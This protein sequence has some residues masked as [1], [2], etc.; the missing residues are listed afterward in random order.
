MPRRCKRGRK[1]LLF[2]SLAC[3]IVCG[4][5]YRVKGMLDALAVKPVLR[6]AGLMSGTSADGIDAAIVDVSR[7]GVRQIAFDTFPYPAGIRRQIFSLFDPATARVD[8]LCH[9]NFVIGE[10]FADAV[11]R[12][13]MRNRM[14]LNSLDLIGSHGQTVCHLPRG[15]SFRGRGFRSTLQIGEPAVIAERTGVTTVADFR[16]RDVAAGGEGAPLVPFTDHFLFSHRLKN[17]ALQNIGGIGNV[18][19]L[20]AGKGVDSI[21]AFDTGPGNMMIDRATFL[22]TDGKRSYDAGGRI[23]AGGKVVGPLLAELMRHEFLCRRP[24]K[25]TGR[26]EFGV[27]LTDSVYRRAMRRGVAPRDILATFTAFTA[28]SIAESYRR[29]LPGRVDE[30]VLCGGGARNGALVAMLQ[31]DL[32][33]A[34][35]LIMDEMGINADAKEAISFAILAAATIRRIPGNAPTATGAARPAVLGKIVPGNPG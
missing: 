29:W 16:T 6:V 2:Y 18:T 33:P 24:P 4:G 9:L 32:Q 28:R 13:T 34:R 3:S 8:D 10:L 20:P 11:I 14:R 25:T 17:R 19:Y 15:R 21:V 12:L 26:E 1:A 27:R 30:V 35:V 22:L 5:G 7:R 23:A 31:R